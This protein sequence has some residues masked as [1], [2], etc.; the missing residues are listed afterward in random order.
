MTNQSPRAH[1]R[2]GSQPRLGSRSTA[3]R[4]SPPHC[5][6]ARCDEAAAEDSTML[7]Q[8]STVPIV[9]Q[10]SHH[11][12]RQHRTT[13]AAK[14]HHQPMA[15]T[16]QS[17]PETGRHIAQ[18]DQQAPTT[19]CHPRT[20]PP[21]VAQPSRV[22][23]RE[24]TGRARLQAAMPWAQTLCTHYP[25]ALIIRSRRNVANETRNHRAPRARAAKRPSYIARVHIQ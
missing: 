9:P 4:C 12:R 1:P 13:D 5:A 23:Q 20:A 17:V 2:L 10:P 21:S 22:G 15:Q 8:D 18:G 14:H 7:S 16:S 6:C 19:P 25:E 24:A 11:P 3:N